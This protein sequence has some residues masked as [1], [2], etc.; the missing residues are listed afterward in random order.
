MPIPRVPKELL[1]ELHEANT[2]FSE[3]RQER[4]KAVD[5]PSYST[6]PRKDAK[7]HVSE[8]EKHVEGRN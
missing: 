1:Q 4:E 8:A 3:A 7:E 6:T 5:T 2:T